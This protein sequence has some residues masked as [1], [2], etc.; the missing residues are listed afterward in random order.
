MSESDTSAIDEKNEENNSTDSQNYLSNL[1]D[2]ILSIINIIIRLLIYYFISA[3][4]LY[5]CKL[6]QSNILPTE[7]E[8]YPYTNTHPKIKSIPINIFTTFEEDQELSMKMKIPYDDINSKNSILD[9]F[10][11]YKEKTNSNFLANYF[12]SIVE[13]LYQFNYMVLNFT[14]NSINGTL[15]EMAIIILGPIIFLLL[16]LLFI[17]AG[18]FYLFYL[19]FANM[20]WFF[21]TNLNDSGSGKPEWDD[22]GLASP[23]AYFS[24][25]ALCL[26][27]V[28]LF[29]TFSPLISLAAS[30][31][32][33]ISVFSI[34]G[35]KGEMNGKNISLINIIKGVFKHYKT[36][37]AC[38]VSFFVVLNA[39]SKLGPVP[40][41]F[42]LLTL[43]LVYFGIL[44]INV[45]NSEKKME[46]FS[47]LVSYDQAA[48]SCSYE[49][50]PKENRGML[51]D[52]LFGGEKLI[53]QLKQIGK[54]YKNNKLN[55]KT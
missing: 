8:C 25:F 18:H 4:V 41:V 30:I 10:R 14:F 54:K 51:Y 34:G 33:I 6:A 1:K 27:F 2:Y 22:V 24:G 46:L 50:P 21:K 47:P 38:V 44:P 35:Y 45:F 9:M 52:A 15:P 39:F 17:F 42:S 32:S 36:L 16:L 19:W 40:G 31:I 12:I 28:I 5:S 3:F 37:I 7:T 23:Y 20:S 43:L 48:K 29:F 26:L 53:K 13:G 11:K 49:E 55:N